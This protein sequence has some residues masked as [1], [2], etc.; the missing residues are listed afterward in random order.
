M[1]V[2]RRYSHCTL[3]STVGKQSPKN[4]LA[5]AISFLKTSSSIRFL[6]QFMSWRKPSILNA[7]AQNI[8]RG[9]QSRPWRGRGGNRGNRGPRRG[10][11]SRPKFAT[12]EV[13]SAQQV[14]SGAGVSIVLKVDQPTGN[15]VLGIVGEVL[16]RGNHPRGIKVRLQDGRVGRVQRI[17]DQGIARDASEGLINL[18]RNG[19]PNGATSAESSS[20]PQSTVSYRHVSDVRDDPYDYDNAPTARDPINLADYIKPSKNRRKK[21]VSKDPENE[22]ATS[23][24]PI[25]HPGTVVCPV[26]GTFEGDEE[27]V[28]F[29]ANTH[30]E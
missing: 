21:A 27:A 18:G 7:M 19:E 8:N 4:I 2:S 25:A 10:G 14:V 28:A 9:S 12:Q 3:P 11:D 1:L 16:G 22:E 23:T 29:H 15:E 24:N 17:V 20:G 26:C 6:L 5:L 30:F 13:P